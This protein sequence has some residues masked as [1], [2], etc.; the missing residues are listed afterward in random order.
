MGRQIEG[1][2]NVMGVGWMIACLSSADRTRGLH[3]L[4]TKDFLW[5]GWCRVNCDTLLRARSL[6]RA[7]VHFLF[8]SSG[9]DLARNLSENAFFLQ[10]A[11][12]NLYDADGYTNGYGGCFYIQPRPA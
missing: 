11:H 4:S 12:G 5:N 7:L 10:D 9:F 8:L 3:S 2:G 6:I 1:G